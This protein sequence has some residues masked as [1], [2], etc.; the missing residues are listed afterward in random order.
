LP[1]IPVDTEAVV[2]ENQVAKE[3]VKIE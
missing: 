2:A 3:E 1:A